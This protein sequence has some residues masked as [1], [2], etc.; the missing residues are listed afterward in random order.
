M[1]FDGRLHGQRRRS[2]ARLSKASLLALVCS[3]S[4]SACTRFE[5]MMANIPV[6]SFL[7]EAPSLDPYE[8]PRPAPPNA[9]PYLSPNGD[10]PVHIVNSDAGLTAFGATVRNPLPARDTTTLRIGQAMY[11]RHCAVCHGA[12]GLGDGPVLNRP[13]EMGKFPFAPNLTL[14]ITV[15]RSDGYL[16]GIVAAGRGLM[17]AYGARM[18][19]LERWSIVVYLRQLQGQLAPAAAL[20]APSAR[21]APVAVRSQA[22]APP[23]EGTPAAEQ[24]GR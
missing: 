14:P 22:V 18:T 24:E 13:G 23:A 16:Y 4:L 1:T 17:P 10:V 3:L 11:D 7:R 8:A 15:A 6:F 5:N 20:I 2:R 21:T 9:V 19:Y 12:Q